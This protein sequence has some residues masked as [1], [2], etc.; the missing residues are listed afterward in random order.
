MPATPDSWPPDDIHRLREL[1]AAG[2]SLSSIAADLDRPKSTVS[3]VARHLGLT[4]DT[5]IT[6]RASKARKVHAANLR[7]LLEVKLLEEAERLVDEMRQPCLVYAFGGR[8]NS[9]AEEHHD[10]PDAVAKLK[11][12]QAAGAAVDRALRIDQHASAGSAD[13]VKSLLSS[14]GQ[15]L[16]VTQPPTEPDPEPSE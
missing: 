14:L 13:G 3:D 8:D 16:G 7:S 6:E 11:L 1:H 9:Y 2:R 12:M 5:A 4:W 15:A 10:Q